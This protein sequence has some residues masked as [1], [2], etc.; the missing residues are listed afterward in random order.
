MINWYMLQIYLHSLLAGATLVQALSGW[1]HQH[2]AEC[3]QCDSRPV[4]VIRAM[5]CQ[6]HGGD[7]QLIRQAQLPC[8]CGVRC[9]GFCIFVTTAKAQLDVPR[10]SSLDF[11]CPLA[12]TMKSCAACSVYFDDGFDLVACQPPLRIHLLH[13]SLLI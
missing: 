7:S 6:H 13:Q 9:H 8:E 1:C 11:A 5:C 10:E 2:G 12:A 4:A 3:A